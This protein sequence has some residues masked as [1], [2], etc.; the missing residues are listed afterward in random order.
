MT[1]EIIQDGITVKPEG[2]PRFLWIHM[3]GM[4]DNAENNKSLMQKYHELFP[5][6]H[7][8]FP[9][10]AAYGAKTIAPSVSPDGKKYETQEE[11]RKASFAE[12]MAK[13]STMTFF[14]KAVQSVKQYAI[15]NISVFHLKRKVLPEI[16]S[17]VEAK[18]R[19]TGISADRTIISGFSLGA[20]A[21][22]YAGLLSKS[23]VAGV[24][25]HSGG[26]LGQVFNAASK[27][28]V[29]F[30]ADE[31]DVELQRGELLDFDKSVRRLERKGVDVDFQTFESEAPHMA[32]Y[33]YENPSLSMTARFVRI[34]LDL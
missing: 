16:M 27:P 14:S 33:Q 30:I 29:L 2:E 13:K 34:Q 8:D 3:H 18:Q 9:Y 15:G 25:S 12:H 31:K 11:L 26:Y 6:A 7:I 19:E 20:G 17:Y 1:S 22:I 21:A 4:G 5:Q 24:V 32:G 28:P 23:K 10:V